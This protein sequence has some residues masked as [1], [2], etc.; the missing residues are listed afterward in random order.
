MDS[1]KSDTEV[2]RV[3]INQILDSFKS[4]M[5][6]LSS[7]EAEQRQKEHGFGLLQN[8]GCRECLIFLGGR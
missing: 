4:G 1:A 3:K 7:Q 5:S 6:G 8:S 2:D